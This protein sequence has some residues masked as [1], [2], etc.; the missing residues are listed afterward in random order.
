MEANYPEFVGALATEI[1]TD[2]KP[3]AARQMAAIFL[4]NSLNSKSSQDQVS[5]HERWKQVSEETRKMVKDTLLSALNSQESDVPRFAAIAIS[6]IACVELPFGAWPNFVE[7]M[8]QCISTGSEVVALA[9]LGCL[10]NVC[11]RIEEVQQMIPEVPDIPDLSVNQML[12]AVVKGVEPE[13]SDAQRHAALT[14]LN[15]SLTFV[16]KNM[17]VKEER[18][19]IM[20]A[21]CGATQAQEPRVR[22]LAF[23]C[24]DTVADIYYEHLPDYMK[25]IYE[26]TM[27]S[28]QADPDEE[29]KIAAGEFWCTVAKIEGSMLE[30][31]ASCRAQGRAIDGHMCKR[32]VHAAV[33]ALVPIFLE[34]LSHHAD[35]YE[36]D[37]HDFRKVGSFALQAFN[38]ASFDLVIPIVIPFCQ[39]NIVHADW[40]KK[41]AAIVAF[42]SIL[43]GPPTTQV[44]GY[45]R[46]IVPVLLQ[47]FND[48]QEIVRDSAVFCI[49]KI[50]EAHMQAVTAFGEADVKLII[51]GL[52]AKLDEDSKVASTSCSALYHLCNGVREIRAGRDDPTNILSPFMQPM[53]HKFL[54]CV[55]R[56]DADENGL[57][58][59]AMTAASSL[60]MASTPDVKEVLRGLL[61]AL[62]QRIGQCLQTACQSADDMKKRDDM[63]VFYLG[64]VT[65]LYQ[66]LEAGDLQGQTDTVMQV[67]LQ[68]LQLQN[69]NC[70]EEAFFLVGAISNTLEDQFVKYLPS[71]MPFVSNALTQFEF[72][73]LCKSA[74]SAISDLSAACT[75]NFQPYCDAIMPLLAGCLQE[76]KVNRELKPAVFTCFGDIALAIG[77]S[78]QTYVDYSCIL[79]MQASHV[80][81]PPE[82]EDLQDFINRLRLSILEA[83]TGI[84]VGLAEG[85]VPGAFAKQIDNVLQFLRYLT[86][87]E[88]LRDEMCLEKSVE[89]LGEL[90]SS[91]GYLDPRQ[92][93]QK[94]QDPFVAQLLRDAYATKSST[95]QELVR[96]CQGT[97]EQL[98]A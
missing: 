78:Y 90:V 29:V 76:V 42:F 39:T 50:V 68:V 32:Y 71:V 64:L 51:Q 21:F 34:S 93:K 31:E 65:A 20:N 26:L 24:L 13:R 5:F 95:A 54:A 3:L 18:D 27:R 4:K 9:C 72:H 92:M 69:Y 44:A 36:E 61:P 79:L 30:D 87:P 8:T 45:I 46:D 82:D 56:S 96:W 63:L 10:G 75:A 52:M 7:A 15:K 28:M 86:S 70:H 89:L 94:L 25:N 58:T 22:Q 53:M 12:S 83:Y 97:I 23:S 88:S 85:K 98:S 43:E 73:A 16:H 80:Q 49:S 67:V 74:L 91:V 38:E 77:G 37:S 66:K 14:A 81:P 62:T 84:V 33:A 40:R 57:Q 55:D 60:I 6:E 1:A 48:Q 17:A 41:D 35:E 11:E 19:F 2:G 59:S 47:S